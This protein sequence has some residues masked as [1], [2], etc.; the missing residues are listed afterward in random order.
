MDVFFQK[1]YDTIKQQKMFKDGDRL[2]LGVSGGPDSMCLLHVMETL[3]ES[4]VI[5]LGVV[6]VHHGLRGIDADADQALVESYCRER[7]IAC[8]TFKADI[9][10][11]AREW[12]L[13]QEEAGRRYRYEVFEQQAR[14][15][16]SSKIVVAHHGDDV[17]ETFLMNLFRGTGLRGLCGIPR[18]RGQIIRPLLGVSR[19]EIEGYLER[20]HIPFRLDLTN[21][22]TDHTRNKIRL[23]VLPYVAREINPRA[24]EKIRHTADALLEAE[25]YIEAQVQKAYDRLVHQEKDGLSVDIKALLEEAPVIQK[26]V[27]LQMIGHLNGG[28]R[29]TYRVHLEALLALLEKDTGKTLDL[30]EGLRAEKTYNRLVLS[31]GKDKPPMAIAAELAVQIPGHYPLILPWGEGV[32]TLEKRPYNE[33]ENQIIPKNIYTKWFDY[34]KIKFGLSVRG[35]LTGDFMVIDQAG[36]TK[37]IKRLFIDQKFPKEQREQQLMLADGSHILWIFGNRISEAY[38]VTKDTKQILIAE[39]RGEA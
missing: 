21:Q 33:K 17:A 22:E 2:L 1:V 30:A 31:K 16:N 18:Q 3:S 37:T 13:S 25:V 12:G 11:L 14:I 5:T 15:L 24:A 35:R 39:I 36:H 28:L 23:E 38:K 26:R 6:H 34:D 29:D 20:H 7:G 27:L 10:A 4:M 8:K 9:N 32:L 19:K